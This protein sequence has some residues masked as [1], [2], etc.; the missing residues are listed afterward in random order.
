M[1]YEIPFIR[2]S[3]P[4]GRQT[5]DTMMTEDAEVADAYRRIEAAGCRMTVEI[6]QTGGIAA[7]IEGPD[8]D[9]DCTVHPNG[10]GLPEAIGAMMKRF[11][12]EA[13][14]RLREEQAIIEAEADG[15]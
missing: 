4:N 14:R 12:P 10:P 1:T 11:D 15:V 5:P 13:A 9:L 2:F 7:C 3:L 6:L 8:G